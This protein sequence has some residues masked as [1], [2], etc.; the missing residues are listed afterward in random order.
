MDASLDVMPIGKAELRR[1][2]RGIALLAFGALLPAASRL[3]EELGLTVVNMRFVKPLDRELILELAAATTASSR[4][5]TTRCRAVPASAVAELLS[6]EGVAL[7]ILHLGLPDLFLEHASRE[8]VLSD[9]G[10]D[11]SGMRDA[12]LRRWPA[13][14]VPPAARVAG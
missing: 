8:Q 3:G 4:W 6:A 1:R 10:L 9:A 12:V 14:A 13:L 7:P 5:K 2:G 11:L